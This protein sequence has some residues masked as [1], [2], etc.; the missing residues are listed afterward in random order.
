M[1]P[2]MLIGVVICLLLVANLFVSLKK[3]G[4]GGNA[5]GAAGSEVAGEPD[6]LFPLAIPAEEGDPQKL[7]TK[8][9]LAEVKLEVELTSQEA[10]DRLTKDKGRL[11]TALIAIFKGKTTADLNDTEAL[12]EE[13]AAAAN[14]IVGEGKCYQVNLLYFVAQKVGG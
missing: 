10:L 8:D 11:S 9:G 7:Q 13:I 14:E 1:K 3:S 4:G 5:E 6:E 12:R 2:I